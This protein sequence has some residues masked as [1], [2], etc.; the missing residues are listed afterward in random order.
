MEEIL[1]VGAK[2]EKLKI[3]CALSA[4]ERRRKEGGRRE[5]GEERRRGRGEGLCEVPQLWP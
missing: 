1:T 2:R 4:V 5:E 3:S